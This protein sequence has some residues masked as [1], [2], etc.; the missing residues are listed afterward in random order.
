MIL[1]SHPG[2]AAIASAVDRRCF[3]P[4]PPFRMNTCQALPL[5][6]CLGWGEKTVVR[7]Q[8]KLVTGL[9][10]TSQDCTAEFSC[11]GCGDR[12]VEE[13][14]HIGHR[15]L[16]VNALVPLAH[17]VRSIRPETQWHPFAMLSCRNRPRE[18]SRSHPAEADKCRWCDLQR[19]AHA[20]RSSSLARR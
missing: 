17:S 18:T 2:T 6:W 5:A 14:P 7:I 4:M 16:S 12:L 11:G 8:S 20:L 10:C 9:H 1:G 19:G 15:F 3:L 13:D